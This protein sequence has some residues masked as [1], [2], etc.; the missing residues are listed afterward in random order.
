[1][2]LSVARLFAYWLDVV[3][4]AAV[5]IGFQALLY[6]VT[7]GFPFD[8]LK[9]G[10]QIVLWVWA[11]ISLPVW[12]CFTG[13]EMRWRQTAGKRL[14]GLR[15]IA[16]GGSGLRFRQAL[17]RTFVKL[18][19]W[20][21]THVILLYPVPWWQGAADTGREWLIIIPNAMMIIY[22]AV[23]LAGRGKR[24]LHDYIAGTEVVAR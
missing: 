15:V 2:R 3:M 4:A 16:V 24:A 14:L 7:G 19:P 5:L 8:H 23:L 13:C 10:Y 9:Y 1:M 21:A 18:L 20:E 22:I 11:T 12:I 17:T 6:A